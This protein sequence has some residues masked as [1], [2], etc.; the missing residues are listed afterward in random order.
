[1]HNLLGA[2]SSC[3]TPEGMMDTAPLPCSPL[4]MST[5]EPGSPG[6]G[7]EYLALQNAW[8]LGL[9]Q[10]DGSAWQ[11]GDQLQP[12]TVSSPFTLGHICQAPHCPL[13]IGRAWDGQT[14][15][16]EGSK[17]RQDSEE[18]ESLRGIR[19]FSFCLGVPRESL[20]IPKDWGDSR[21]P[22]A[23]H[24]LVAELLGL[25]FAKT[26][27][28]LERLKK[29]PPDTNWQRHFTKVDI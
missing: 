17:K 23:L 26:T 19:T 15:P 14:G 29:M 8:E 3:P 25:P 10:E 7:Q 24:H 21:Q 12:E 13:C 6:L 1:M 28:H 11:G 20:E 18:L 16:S 5:S 9:L 4:L 27:D 22:S 2:I